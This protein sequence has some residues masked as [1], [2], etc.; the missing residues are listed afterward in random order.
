MFIPVS[1]IY[2][3][4]YA[5]TGVLVHRHALTAVL[6]LRPSEDSFQELCLCL[7]CCAGFL[8]FCVVLPLPGQLAHTFPGGCLVCSL[9]GLQ[10]M[11]L[12]RFCALNLGSE[13]FMASVFALL[14]H[15]SSC[16]LGSFKPRDLNVLK[17]LHWLG[18]GI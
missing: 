7:P 15:L 18:S 6:T 16:S 4:V 14:A 2:L 17:K 8:L 12:H 13:T 1:R 3:C 9:T 10:M 11:S 5:C